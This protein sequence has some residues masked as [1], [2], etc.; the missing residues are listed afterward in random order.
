[1]NPILADLAAAMSLC[2]LR[3]KY[4]PLGW[5]VFVSDKGRWWAATTGREAVDY[6]RGLR[7]ALVPDAVDANDADGLAAALERRTR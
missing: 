3:Q 4:A 6:K 7:L 2:A 5:R 1:M